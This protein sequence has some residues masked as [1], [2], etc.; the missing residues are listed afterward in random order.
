MRRVFRY[1]LPIFLIV[2]LLSLLLFACK[3]KAA[4]PFDLRIAGSVLSWDAVDEAD[5]YVVD[6]T[7]P[8]GNG[9]TIRVTKPTFTAPQ[10]K[11]GDYLYTV[12]AYTSKNVFI[13]RSASVLYHLGVGSHTDPILI[14]SA[15]E[16]CALMSENL[17]DT[18]TSTG[19]VTV[20]FGKKTVYAPLYYTLTADLDLTGVKTTPIGR[21]SA[22]F[23]GYF[24]GNGH[25]I[26]NLSFTKTYNG[27]GGLFGMIENA[28]VK[29]LTL[30]DASLVMGHDSDVSGNDLK[31]GILVAYSKG[32][33]IDN[34]HV[35]GNIDFMTD[36]DTT[37][38]LTADVGGLIGNVVGGRVFSSSFS[39][40]INARYSQVFAG[41]I[42]GY[43]QTGTPDLV[44]TNCLSDATVNAYATGYNITQKKST[45]KARA[46]V[47]IGSISGANV[48]A[49][50]VAV[51]TATAKA[52]GQ[53][54]TGT[55]AS[56]IS[57]GVFGHTAGSGQLNSVPIIDLFYSPTTLAASGSRSDLGT[58]KTAYGLT[59]EELLDP[60]S[61]VVGSASAL[62]FDGIWTMGDTHPILR[63]TTQTIAHEGV[64]LVVESETEDVTYSFSLQ[65]TFLPQYYRLTA[66]GVTRTYVG[67]HLNDLLSNNLGLSLNGAKEVVLS[68]EGMEDIRFAV[69][70]TSSSSSFSSV[71]LFYGTYDT[72][73]SR[74]PETYEGIRILDATKPSEPYTCSGKTI[75]VTIVKAD[76]T[77]AE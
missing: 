21:S 23:R 64:T 29:N 39:G 36:T 57:A 58:D 40:T 4:E 1:L 44:V 49:R 8:D 25:T 42:A 59:A 16:L 74:L 52:E 33:L 15:E 73:I 26:S 22:P 18:D 28:V 69:M 2:L 38:T 31:Y 11:I 3:E 24:D 5:H 32:S 77:P 6:C 13:A 14:S 30:Q 17:K 53:A 43:A 56:D 10:T 66:S 27:C 19:T 7:T 62:D 72:A 34:C 76:E 50:N 65:D 20:K 68:S 70:T 67:I 35:T 71:Y 46:G 51:G 61:Y 9:Y 47:L 75:T 55:V 60:L 41:G 37:G 63:G 45:A 54:A 48:I 12:S